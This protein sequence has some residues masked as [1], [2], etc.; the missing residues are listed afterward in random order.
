MLFSVFI[1]LHGS[2]RILGY[3]YYFRTLTSWLFSVVI[4]F[5]Y[6]VVDIFNDLWLQLKVLLAVALS[7]YHY[8]L[9]MWQ[10]D[11]AQDS[12]IHSER[13]YRIMNEVPTLLMIGIVLLVIIRPF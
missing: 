9:A 5:G 4:I 1:Q 12:N 6:S 2:I 8:W 13:F 3:I 10:R 7:A 11:F